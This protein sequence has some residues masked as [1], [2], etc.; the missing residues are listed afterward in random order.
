MPRIWGVPLP[1]ALRRNSSSPADRGDLNCD[2]LFPS[3]TAGTADS[4]EVVDL[5]DDEEWAALGLGPS[6]ETHQ[7][8]GASVDGGGP[9]SSGSQS[10]A[11]HAP[12]SASGHSAGVGQHGPVQAWSGPVPESVQT[13]GVGDPV[14]TISCD[15]GAVASDTPAQAVA[16]AEARSTSKS[17]GRTT[18]MIAW[19]DV[20]AGR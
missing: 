6:A 13:C 18:P 17:T 14:D 9:M 8:I 19:S 1:S 11:Q 4:C 3:Q 20:P 2:S 16:A 5:F 7:A 15:E 12:A 10:E